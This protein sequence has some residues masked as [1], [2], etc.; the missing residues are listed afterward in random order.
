MGSNMEQTIDDKIV[1]SLARV[2]SDF[3]KDIN[4]ADSDSKHDLGPYSALTDS[5][6]QH[7]IED[8]I[9]ELGKVFTASYQNGLG[10]EEEACAERIFINYVLT[11]TGI[12][13]K[14]T[15]KKKN[16]LSERDEELIKTLVKKDKEMKGYERVLN[17][18]KGDT[19]RFYGVLD[20]IVSR[21]IAMLKT[22]A[23]ED[24]LTGL[25]NRRLFEKILKEEVARAERSKGKYVFS[26][27]CIDL[28]DLKE[29]NSGE[30]GYGAGDVYLKNFARRLSSSTRGGDSVYR[31]GGDEFL[32][33]VKHIQNIKDIQYKKGEE[34]PKDEKPKNQK[35]LALYVAKRLY[36]VLSGE[37]KVGEET[38]RKFNLSMGV[39]T[40]RIIGENS[41]TNSKE[42]EDA[43]QNAMVESKFLSK[44]DRMTNAKIQD[45]EDAYGITLSRKPVF[46]PCQ[47][48]ELKNGGERSLYTAF[49][50]ALNQ[51][52]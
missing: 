48:D 21:N 24:S 47:F 23:S 11:K 20:N 2:F 22:H 52:R 7:D 42:L 10:G 30:G 51:R 46:A 39:A 50:D 44:I 26:L 37:K 38:K 16:L 43:A 41:I 35:E 36:K 25:P 32:I 28:N 14:G 45:I 49:R 34:P 9:L 3:V 4:T 40:Y 18:F 5:S 6:K 29:K 27:I 1:D 12:V 19:N 15:L 17:S 33:M 13:K 31:W 8:V